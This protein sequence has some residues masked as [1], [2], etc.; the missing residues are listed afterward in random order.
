MSKNDWV[1]LVLFGFVFA[2]WPAIVLGVATWVIG[3]APMAGGIVA[4]VTFL[5]LAWYVFRAGVR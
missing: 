4:L 3:S 2:A 5:A 1:L